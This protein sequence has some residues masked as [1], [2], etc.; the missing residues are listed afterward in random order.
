[1]QPLVMTLIVIATSHDAGPPAVTL[2][3]KSGTLTGQVLLDGKPVERGSIVIRPKK[4]KLLKA[5]LDENGKFAFSKIPV[6]DY[7][8]GIVSDLVPKKYRSSKNSGLEV[9]VEVGKNSVKF[10]LRS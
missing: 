6:G 9:S 8:V 10:V 2:E 3:A 5:K 1:M 7:Q 4:G